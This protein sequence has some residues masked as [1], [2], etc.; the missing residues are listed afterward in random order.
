[1]AFAVDFSEINLLA[2]CEYC[3][4]SSKD[5]NINVIQ[6]IQA[7]HFIPTISNVTFWAPSLKACKLEFTWC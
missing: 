1:M 4:V 2:M 6:M 3:I 7:T 5:F